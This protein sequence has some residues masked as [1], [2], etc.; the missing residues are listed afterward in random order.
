MT[1][2]TSVSSQTGWRDR[3]TTTTRAPALIGYVAMLAMG[4]TFGLWGAWAPI[5]EAATAPG[6]IT[7]FGRN[8]Q[9]QHL[10]GG[11]I[12]EIRVLEGDH[13]R[14]GDIMMVLDETAAKGQLNRLIKQRV[15][16]DI[17]AQR[18][19]AEREG[20]HAFDPHPPS[21]KLSGVQQMTD[22]LLEEQKEFSARLARF[23]SEHEILTTR[24]EQLDRGRAGLNEQKRAI[25]KQVVV[26]RSELD[27]KESLLQKAL[28]DRSEYTDLLRIDA[29]LLGQSA[30]II[31]QQ[32][33]T[34]SQ[35]AE[36][37]EQIERL[38]TQR[39]EDAVT[40]L[41]EVNTSLRDIDEQITSAADV[42]TRTVIRAPADG[43]VVTSVYN[44]VGNVV[45][46]GEKI[47]EIL[48]T[49]VR[50]L[51]EAR[52]LPTDIDVVHIGQKARLHFTALNARLTPEVDATVTH[53]S[54][55]RLIDQTTR[56]PYYRALL[57]ISQRLPAAIPEEQLRPGMP[58]EVFIN[59]GERTFFE[60]LLKPLVDSTQH[61]FIEE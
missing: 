54:A 33:S 31:A 55:D 41:T 10:E 16:L 47:M 30:S 22:I 42:L 4:G 39:I 40:K 60:Y 36:A 13:V 14:R 46:S 11:I 9:V 17:K 3:L 2:T 32:L 8:V 18:L 53:V 51:V 28:I 49:T 25:E 7:A 59:T 29:D 57:Q 20:L 23:S 61:A 35:I 43:I 5:S 21:V 56:Q 19:R 38:R 48:P 24:L 34:D 50:P 26:V 37:R 45:A 6:T 58:V 44:F 12:K 52:L 1:A 15:S 27:R